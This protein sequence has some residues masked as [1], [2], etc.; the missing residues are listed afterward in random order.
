MDATTKTY[1][2]MI[3]SKEN[4]QS[5]INCFEL[6]WQNYLNSFELPYAT[7]RQLAT[8]NR[9]R[10]ILC[11]WGYMHC[12]DIKDINS[13]K[14]IA[15]I[16]VSLEAIHKASVIIDDV[17]D[18]DNKRRGVDCFHIEF[19]EKETT[20]FAVCL[21]S[22]AIKNINEILSTTIT[23]QTILKK[24]INLLCDTIID[25]C[26]GAIK[27]IN[28]NIDDRFN[29]SRI[30]QIIHSETV[31]LLKNSLLVGYMASNN[32]DEQL[33]NAFSNIGSKCGYIFQVMN[34]LE[35]FC[36]PEYILSHKGN[37]NADCLRSRKNVVMPYL[38]STASRKDCALIKELLDS[39]NN[40]NVLKEL[41]E[42]YHIRKKIFSDMDDL[43]S[44][45]YSTIAK[46]PNEKVDYCWKKVFPIFVD[47]LIQYCVSVLDG[48]PQKW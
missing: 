26:I 47:K 19:G 41:F 1:Y 43:Q 17:I 27:E 21:L 31:A 39:E 44:A 3:V 12:R 42:K 28:T 45:I 10:P 5:F 34:D 38:Y 36:N 13:F 4:P 16:A 9:L 8:G 20:F 18:G 40:Y 29:L 22:G 32:C 24:S 14:D 15:T 7:S 33:I 30:N 37:L 46:L 25:M 48:T 23:E 6:E 11:C 2:D 35:P